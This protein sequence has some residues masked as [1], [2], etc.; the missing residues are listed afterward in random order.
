MKI[1]FM[2]LSFFRTK[3]FNTVHVFNLEPIRIHMNLVGL[4][5]TDFDDLGSLS[6]H[7]DY[8]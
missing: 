8:N 7:I 4:N 1:Y 5:L 2:C 6:D 3:L